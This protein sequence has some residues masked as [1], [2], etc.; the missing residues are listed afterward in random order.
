MTQPPPSGPWDAQQP[1]QWQQGPGVPSQPGAPGPYGGPGQFGPPQQPW[2]NPLPP[3]KSG[4]SKW[5]LGAVALVAVIAVTAVVAV[6]CTKSSNSGGG[7]TP[8]PNNSGIASADDTGPV[9]IITEDP[10][11]APWGPVA[12]TLTNVEQKGWDKRDVSIPANSWTPELRSQYMTVAGAL[13]NAADQSVTLAKLTPHRVM[14]ELYEQFI[15]Y[16]RAFADRIP[17]Y[18]LTDESLNGAA[19]SITFII[20]NIC[21]A[22]SSG[23]A[24]ARAPL[25]P[26]ATK[27]THTSSVGNIANPTQFMQAANHGCTEWIRVMVETNTNPMYMDW[28]QE[29]T[30]IPASSWDEKYKAEN[31]AVVPI[32]NHF[33]DG[34]EEVG[35]QSSNQTLE[36]FGVLAAQYFRAY[37]AGIPTYSPADGYLN[38]TAAY[39]PVAVKAACTAVGVN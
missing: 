31:L 6:S 38:D 9:G 17:T 5:V 24:A 1:G 13:R 25:V 32:L 11:C 27:P 33:A 20:N 16:S 29:D 28:L 3:K 8:T 26:A 2:P 35:R 21:R 14:R 23:S 15:A 4:V 37:V 36:D 18:T 7:G 12:T 34:L 39:V 22:I 19:S 30:S 10:T